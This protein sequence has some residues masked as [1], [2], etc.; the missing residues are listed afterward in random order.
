MN[1][2]VVFIHSKW[3]PLGLI[4]LHGYEDDKNW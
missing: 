2:I 3:N 4:Y 1:F